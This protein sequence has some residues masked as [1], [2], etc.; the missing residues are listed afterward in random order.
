[1]NRFTHIAQRSVIGSFRFRRS[2][3]ISNC[4]KKETIFALSSGPIT[5]SG[6]SV[7]RLSGPSSLACLQALCSVGHSDSVKIHFKERNATLKYLYC[8]VSKDKLDQSLVLWFP[9]P[10]SFTGEDVVELHVHGSRAVITAVFEALEYLDGK[11][12]FGNIRAAENGEFTRR[13]FENGRMDLTEV[14]GLADLLESET[15]KQRAQA[16][17]QMD[18]HLRRTYEQWRCGKCNSVSGEINFQS[19]QELVRCL[20]HSEAVIDF[21]DDD[22]EDDVSDAALY[23]L[24]PRV[25]SLLSELE[26]H[27]LSGKKGELVREGVRIALVGPPNAGDRS[28]DS[29]R[30]Q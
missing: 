20:A 25:Q 24:I 2:M 26:R 5:K 30:A 14:E 1:M 18:G 12:G 16:L 29:E 7:I 27:L 6:V 4:V 19:R 17:R 8:P 13:A 22:R 9:G 21:G 3:S 10:R 23:A 28:A 15:A 11:S